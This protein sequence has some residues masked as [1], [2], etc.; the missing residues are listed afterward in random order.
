MNI[1][2]LRILDY[3]ACGATFILPQHVISRI[4]YWLTRIE[5]PVVKNTIIKLYTA[6]FRLNMSEAVETD[7]LA[8]P[9]MNALF[10]RALKPRVRPLPEDKTLLVSPADGVV[11]EFGSISNTLLLQAKGYRYSHDQ[12]LGGYAELNRPFNDGLFATIYLSPKDYHRVHMPFTGRLTD[13]IY[14][15]GRLHSVSLMTTRTIPEIFTKNERLVCLFDT[16]AG[17]LAVVLVGAIN[18]A[19]IETVWAGLVTPPPG[20]SITL[21]HYDEPILLERG[22]ELGRFNMGSTVVLLMEKG[23]FNWQTG[24]EPYSDIR[25]GEAMAAASKS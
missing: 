3:L 24:L 9:S 16:D 12:L 14:I 17:R 19:A 2:L 1:T 25:M 11:S 4:V 10:T 18:V 7:P 22:A 15:P 21:T 8:Y 13:M 23:R 5:T 20:K 6:A